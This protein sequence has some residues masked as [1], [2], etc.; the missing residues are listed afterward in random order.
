MFSKKM[1]M[2]MFVVFVS[3]LLMS[4]SAAARPLAEALSTS[5]TYQGRL[6]DGGVPATGTYDFKFQLYDAL[7]DGG[8]V[9][10]DLPLENV[11]VSSGLFTVQLDFGNVFDGRALYLQIGV[12]PGTSTGVY[13]PLTPR[14]QLTP[15]PYSLYA[16]QAGN[17]DT[18]DGQHSG[19]FLTGTSFLNASNINDGTLDPL[20]FSAFNDLGL[21]GF[22]DN[23]S[24]HIGYNNGT[25]NVNLN[26][27]MLDGY[28]AS[29]FVLAA[30]P[31]SHDHWGQTWSGSGTGLTLSG[32]TAGLDASGSN[33]GVS[34]S[35]SGLNSI[36]VK[37]NAS[38]MNSFGILGSGSIG[39]K[40]TSSTNG[41]IGVRG[42]GNGTLG[43]GV[44]GTGTS[45]GVWGEGPIGIYGSTAA[46]GG[47]AVY[48]Y[49]DP[50]GELDYA[51]YFDGNVQ[52]N[53]SLGITSST[54]VTNLNADRL[55]SLHAGNANGN[56][57]VSNGTRNVNLNADML[58]G[59]HAN[60]FAPTDHNHG[61]ASW[62]GAGTVLTLTGGTIG[63]DSYGTNYG[64]VSRSSNGI[65]IYGNSN[66]LDGTG[67]E[68]VG[69][70][71]VY[72]FS[73]ISSGYGVFGEAS[74]GADSD[75]AGFFEGNV[76]VD[77]R[78]SA[79]G[80]ETGLS[81]S[82]GKWGVTGYGTGSGTNYGVY[83][84][85]SIGVEGNGNNFGVYGIGNGNNTTG[86]NGLGD[87]SNTIGVNGF[88]STGVEGESNISGGKAIYGLAHDG[89]GNYAGYFDGN[90]QI[91]GSLGITSTAL[92]TNLNAD[93]LD[94]KQA[95]DFVLTS[96]ANS[97]SH[98]G[99]TWSGSGTGLTLS[100]GS[101][102]V[103]TSGSSYGLNATSTG[104]SSFGIYSTASGSNSTAIYGIGP[105]GLYG[106]SNLV[107]G[108][109][110]HGVASGGPG[111][112]NY[113]GYFDGNVVT[114]G[115]VFIGS[116]TDQG[117]LINTSTGAYLTNGGAWTNSS[118]RNLKANF[119]A[120][121]DNDILSAIAALPISTWNY[122]VQDASIRHIGPMAQDFYAA[123]H[124]GED[125]T[126]IAT[127]DADGVALAGIQAL[128]LQNQ[129]Q[130]AE[131][132]S[133]QARLSQLD[134]AGSL[135]TSASNL[136]LWIGFGV[137]ALVQ[138]L[139]CLVLLHRKTGKS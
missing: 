124:V 1:I 105:N 60:A 48:G 62:T 106:V 121:K 42:E 90:V 138:A 37:G 52:I 46:S 27:D 45:Q 7:T 114:N 74:A 43:T 102:G 68:G 50:D 4:S 23:A 93:M 104:N 97:H 88:G 126:H 89:S 40:G 113:A 115:R 59:S 119:T 72:G 73:P 14:Q 54:L 61:G 69:N 20:R 6:S 79:Y 77:G 81:G 94:G 129:Q 123:F 15:T 31:A 103:S 25:R 57:P 76:Q 127:V 34:G 3:V 71:G 53:G 24:G 8:Q 101:T 78:L 5:F 83:G 86:V 128:I 137:L 33:Y 82:G 80:W 2:R 30:S 9:G 35:A 87:G 36:G 29:D 32:G 67:V 39:V 110:I 18:L 38:G 136:P 133:L 44:Y 10:G 56:I 55:D 75:Y 135:H 12:R 92:V 66:N 99:Q 109:G 64:V 85:G 41:S 58:D 118:D 134:Q 112:N 16:L 21:E 11:P 131:I 95:T 100:G 120:V 132:Q 116:G 22:L 47:F 108:A 19:S 96:A 26:A 17:A 107:N 122:K 130:A 51:G 117:G 49:A 28:H 13:T 84:H 65:A 91:N 139:M 125:D 70:Y 111:N 98:W 63:L